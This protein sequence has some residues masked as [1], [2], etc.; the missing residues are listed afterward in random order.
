MSS[1]QPRLIFQQP[2]TEF[3]VRADVS[4]AWGQPHQRYFSVDS[5]IDRDVFIRM[6][7][8]VLASER[9]NV[10]GW[11]M[12]TAQENELGRGRMLED[13]MDVA[14]DAVDLHNKQEELKNKVR[15]TP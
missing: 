8:R 12:L 11:Q 3:I 15:Q 1:R 10:K 7:G 2:R 5:G 13:V 14:M 9:L 4:D 6:V